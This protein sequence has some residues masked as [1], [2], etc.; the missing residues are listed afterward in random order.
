MN[1]FERAV[2]TKLRFPS[3]VGDLTTE[4]VWELNLTSKTANHPCLD[5]LARS[6]HSD[7]KEIEEGSFVEVKPD[8]RKTVL[9]LR[10]DILKHIIQA[11]LDL[12]AENER[13]AENAER[14]RRLLAALN[15]KEEAELTNMSKEDLEKEIA[16]LDA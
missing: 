10:L 12:K 13:A 16:K 7:L 5:S 8:P 11:K 6:A 4:Q 14:K 2:R 15:V 3:P 1:I 9:E